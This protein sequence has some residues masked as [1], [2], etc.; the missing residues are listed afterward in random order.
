MNWSL[1][2]AISLILVLAPITAAQDLSQFDLSTNDGVNAARE[3]IAGKPLDDRSKNC[4]RRHA[5]LP[6]I[7]MVGAFAFDYGCRLQ[8][9]FIKSSYVGVDD[10]SMSRSAL[11]ALGWKTA[12]QQNREALAQAWVG[13]GT[14]RIRLCSVS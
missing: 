6:G 10:S 13:K 7:V 11:E 9:A 4:I 1:K 8:G 3:A 5:S 14:T 2:L 12:N